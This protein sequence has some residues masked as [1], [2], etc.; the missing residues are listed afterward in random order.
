MKFL[1]D[2]AFFQGR[3]DDVSARVRN[4]VFKAL[5]PELSIVKEHLQEINLH[6]LRQKLSSN[7]GKERFGK[8]RDV[9]MVISTLQYIIRLP[10]FNIVANSVDSIT[11]S[12]IDKYYY[13]LQRSANGIIQ[14]G[15][16]IASLYIRDVVSLFELE[17]KVP[18][19]FQFCLQPVDVWVRKIAEKLEIIP[20]NS[21][22]EKVRQAIINICDKY[23]CSPLQFNQGAWYAGKF[24]FD[25]LIENLASK[26][27]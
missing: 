1:F 18:K 26:G 10:N 19:E 16:K 21:T 14:V 4:A 24:S 17:G 15:P 20:K 22:D 11:L 13:E 8:A 9:D 23:S 5:D 7:I 6:R 25:L 3:L 27:I 2:R 12:E